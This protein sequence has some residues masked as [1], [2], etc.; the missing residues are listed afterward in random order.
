MTTSARPTVA[1]IGGGIAGL[2]AAWELVA[3]AGA[4]NGTAAGNGSG[5]GNGTGPQV[6]IFESADRI[7]GKLQSSEFAGRQVDTAAD[8]FL[9]RRPEA[10]DL[11]SELGLETAPGTGGRLGRFDLGPGTATHD[12]RGAE[13][14][15]S[16]PLVAA[17]P[18]RDPQP[19]RSRSGWPGTW[20]PPPG[21][22]PGHR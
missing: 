22:E 1:V 11:V 13:P 6:H 20:S 8:A 15:G 17:P 7:G 9:A 19:R 4:G 16:D 18:F 21:I 5:A 10:T 2:A 14:R 12:A 3:G